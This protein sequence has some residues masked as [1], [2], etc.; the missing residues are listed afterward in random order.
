[1]RIPYSYLFP[2]PTIQGI[3]SCAN[4][5]CGYLV[6]LSIIEGNVTIDNMRNLE[7]FNREPL[8]FAAEWQSL[9]LGIKGTTYSRWFAYVDSQDQFESIKSDMLFSSDESAHP[10]KVTTLPSPTTGPTSTPLS[11]LPSN[12]NSEKEEPNA[13]GLA[14]G[15]IIGI[16][17][18][19]GI[20]GLVSII[21][22]IWFF[23]HRRRQQT[24]NQGGPGRP[25]GVERNRTE[26]LMAEKEASTGTDPSPHSPY[27]D[28]GILVGGPADTHHEGTS[29][30]NGAVAPV[31]PQQTPRL[32]QP[33]DQSRSYTP[34]SDRGARSPGTHATSIA[35]SEDTSRAGMGSPTAGRATPHGSLAPQYAHLVEEG[36]TEEEIRRLED[37]ERQLDAAIEQAG[38]R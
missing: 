34:Y 4:T 3:D 17:V 27:S 19:C 31:L 6:T 12:P 5:T 25:Y 24:T 26:D 9:S 11:N 30:P 10:E 32:Q 18:A 35:H 29:I 1:M 37:E 20:V 14:T 13:G 36:M 15:A 28:E 8:Y 7:T 16:A 2:G 38:R 21:A 22:A 23:L 33:H